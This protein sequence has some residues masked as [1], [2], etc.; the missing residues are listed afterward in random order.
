[1]SSACARIAVSG[2]PGST[3]DS[4]GQRRPRRLAQRSPPPPAR[5]RPSPRPPERGRRRPRRAVRDP[6]RAR[7]RRARRH[8]RVQEQL[9]PLVAPAGVD[10]PELVRLRGG[11]DAARLDPRGAQPP[12]RRALARQPVDGQGRDRDRGPAL[13]PARRRR[14][15][16]DHP[17]RLARREQGEGRRGRLD[18]HAAGRPQPLHLAREDAAAED[19]GGLPCDQAEQALVE[20]RGS[21]RRG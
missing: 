21:S 10:R 5:A 15:R 2:R 9:H 18:D 13:L 4:E 17:R 1:M 16:G 19:Q 8:R 12:A 3:R 7:D 6:D 11:R 14:L 20:G